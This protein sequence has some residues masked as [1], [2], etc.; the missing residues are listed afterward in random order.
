M[1]KTSH[2]NRSS[3]GCD[4]GDEGDEGDEYDEMRSGLLCTEGERET[5][6]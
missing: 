4:E 2:S 6:F 3:D 5:P 1:E